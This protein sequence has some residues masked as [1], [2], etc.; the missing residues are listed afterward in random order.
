M[1]DRDQH[2]LHPFQTHRALSKA[3]WVLLQL[4]AFW[5]PGFGVHSASLQLRP[6]KAKKK[7]HCRLA[8]VWETKAFGNTWLI[9]HKSWCNKI[10]C[11]SICVFFLKPPGKVAQHLQLVQ[12][13]SYSRQ[14]KAMWDFQEPSPSSEARG[15]VSTDK[16]KIKHTL[17]G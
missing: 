7:C 4:P 17:E 12:Y 10:W 1:R 11:L 8:I 15:G 5:G 3:K 16:C 6:S 2:A 13:F 14:K 9:L